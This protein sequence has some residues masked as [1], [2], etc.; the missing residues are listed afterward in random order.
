[1]KATDHPQPVA[2]PVGAFRWFCG[3][4]GL[5]ILTAATLVAV[6]VR[7]ALFYAVAVQTP[8]SVCGTGAADGFSLLLL[9]EVVVLAGAAFGSSL[10][11]R[12]TF[13]P[14]TSR[15]LLVITFAAYLTGF[16]FL[17]VITIVRYV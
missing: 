12:S 13:L 15:M 14:R 4:V 3:F 17:A 11:R 7:P 8:S 1:M 9:A 6:V 5:A 16:L 2:V 10:C